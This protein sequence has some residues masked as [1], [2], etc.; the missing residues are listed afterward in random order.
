[1]LWAWFTV[2][3]SVPCSAS[4]IFSTIPLCATVSKNL[5]LWVSLLHAMRTC[6]YAH[7]HA[8]PFTYLINWQLLR[9]IGGRWKAFP[10]ATNTRITMILKGGSC[11]VLCLRVCVSVQGC[12]AHSS[13]PHWA[14]CSFQS[15]IVDDR[16]KSVMP[17]RL[18]RV[19]EVAAIESEIERKGLWRKVQVRKGGL[20]GGGE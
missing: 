12:L 11:V 6:I 9:A 13:L 15:N 2:C 8:S 7:F 1:M 14:D 10:C 3:Y 18:Q 17:I 16:R 5:C 20:G 19:K 4:I